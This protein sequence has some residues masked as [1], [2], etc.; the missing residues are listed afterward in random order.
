LSE[1]ISSRR[2]QGR[3]DGRL[4]ERDLVRRAT[5][6]VLN[7]AYVWGSDEDGDDEI[8]DALKDLSFGGL[9]LYTKNHNA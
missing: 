2:L 6:I 7:D 4:G 9:D 3:I 5:M 8:S 1:K